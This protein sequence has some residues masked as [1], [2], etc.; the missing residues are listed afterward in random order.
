[1]PFLAKFTKIFAWVLWATI[2]HNNVWYAMPGKVKL[3]L[4]DHCLSGGAWQIV[5]FKKLT[6]NS[7]RL[8]DIFDHG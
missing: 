6:E 1:M 2:A 8:R 7:R 3:H 5:D 4:G